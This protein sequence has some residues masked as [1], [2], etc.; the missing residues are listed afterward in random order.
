[1]AAARA[2]M[3]KE[4][5]E[6]LT[7]SEEG[8]PFQQPQQQQLATQQGP[9]ELHLSWD[10]GVRVSSVALTPRQDG[11]AASPTLLVGLNRK[12][13]LYPGCS[14][15]AKTEVQLSDKVRCLQASRDQRVTACFGCD[16]VCRCFCCT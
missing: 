7:S 8:D 12:V 15:T 10:R 3:D 1:L 6:S 16:E 9:S 4:D 2:A 13:E 11:C 14:S 5:L